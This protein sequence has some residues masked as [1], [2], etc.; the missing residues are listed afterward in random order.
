M[1][2]LTSL[3]PFPS[4]ALALVATAALACSDASPS[5]EPAAALQALLDCAAGGEAPRFVPCDIVDGACQQRIAQIAAC[6]WG[7]PAAAVVQPVVHTLSQTQY[8]ARLHERATQDTET[9]ALRSAVDASLALLGLID[10]GD[11]SLESVVE[12]NARGV[13][14]YYEPESKSITVIEQGSDTGELEA[15]ATLL[16]EMVHALQDAEHDLSALR[17]GGNG[18]SDGDVALRSLVEGEAK[19]HDLL[20][21]AAAGG[22]PL[23]PER[24]QQLLEQRRVLS[25]DLLFQG[26]S[27]LA[28]SLQSVPY[29]Y[30]PEWLLGRWLEG[31]REAL[32][33][34]YDAIPTALLGVLQDAWGGAEEPV[35]PRHYPAPNVYTT[36]GAEPAPG[37]ELIPLA[38]DR[39]GAFSVYALAR[40]AGDAPAGQQLALGWRGDQ[41]DVYELDAGGAAARWHVSFASPQQA[42]A[43]GDLLQRNAL[44]SVRQRGNNVVGVVSEGGNR[45][46]WLFGPASP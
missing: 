8:R 33:A 12:R 44:V 2:R 28:S 9:Q 43:F 18:S 21:L 16:H 15:N 39:L 34:T 42:A 5:A 37:S 7:G 38:H 24:L 26:A 46:E 1:P 19:L 29:L 20:F 23:S 31:G 11:L 27:A 3:L 36:D 10:G 6:Q 32:R 25:E 17:A 4:R 45:P 35:V 41:L 14:A 22:S 13:L 40:L 30:G